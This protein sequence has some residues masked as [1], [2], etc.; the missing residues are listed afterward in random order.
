MKKLLLYFV[1]VTLLANISIAN[2][3]YNNEE[4]NMNLSISG[5]IN[6]YPTSTNYNIKY[7]KAN[8]IFYPVETWRQKI[9]SS[10]IEPQA[11][12]TEDSLNFEWTNVEKQKL[13]FKTNYIIKTNQQFKKIKKKIK[14]P[15][16]NLPDEYIRYTKPS[17]NI[18]SDND[19]IIK[20]A[21]NLAEGEDD[22]YIVTNKL[23]AWVEDNIKYSLNTL[24]ENASQKASWVL[25]NRFGVCDE[26]TSLFIALTRSLGIPARFISGVAYTG[27]NNIN[28]W[29]SHAWAEVYFPGYEWV[30]FDIAYKQFGFIDLSHINLKQ[31]LDSSN[32]SMH[33]EWK[34][35]G[36][37]VKPKDLDIKV[38]LKKKKQTKDKLISLRTNVFEEHIGFGS[39]NLVEVEIKNLKDYYLSTELY[40]SKSKELEL[41]GDNKKHA[42]LKPNEIKKKDWLIRIN[43][44]LDEKYVYTFPV[45]ANSLRNTSSIIFFS[46]SVDDIVYSRSEMEEI[47]KQRE[48]ETTKVYSKNIELNCII[49]KEEYY[50]DEPIIA[51]CYVK[52]TGNT[53]LNNLNLCLKKQ[54]KTFDLGITQSVEKNF[55]INISNI[56]K[57]ENIITVENNEVSKLVRLG[58]SVIDRPKIE[59]T[60]LEYPD[61]VSY[62][63]EFNIKFTA[64][65][66]S[67]AMPSDIIV[68]VKGKYFSRKWQLK[69]LNIKQEFELNLIG[70]DLN[71][72]KNDFKIIV[73]YKD[74][75][76]KNYTARED[77]YITLSNVNL[78]QRI[79]IFF[80]N[81]I[82]SIKY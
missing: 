54:C 56:G 28:D 3:F 8:L 69:K 37:S 42:V 46:S 17:E 22:L 6:I 51:G 48:K 52:N 80:R 68:E 13:N 73:N 76:G 72:D 66:V 30:P 60:A 11:E 45:G 82:E 20:L 12:I 23:A 44:D 79:I 70:K 49:E 71:L 40:L 67:R 50:L 81:I 77:F 19:D 15:V 63:D 55:S 21:S 31:S 41:A 34:G 25:L 53:M 74:K 35:R 36:I 4:V 61:D 39:Y 29:G 64:V 7:I 18:D 47:L 38:D 32:P 33:Y 10:D 14:F 58:Y 65:K 26:L 27:W 62:N 75:D 5:E 43:K 9:I 16:T 24:T 59:I 78:I 1:I 57:K 2:N